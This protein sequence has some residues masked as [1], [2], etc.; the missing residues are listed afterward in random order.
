MESSVGIQITLGR[1]CQEQMFG[2]V[3]IRLHNKARQ[4]Q[5]FGKV[6]IRLHNKARQEEVFG[7][8]GIR[9]QYIR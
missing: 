8:V 5:V 6:G 2:K 4:E 7:K 3:G 1:G 9:L